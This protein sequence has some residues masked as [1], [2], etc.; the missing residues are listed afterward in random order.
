MKL[1]VLPSRHD[2]ESVVEMLH[3]LGW[4]TKPVGN[5][6]E[7]QPSKE[8]PSVL[9]SAYSYQFCGTWI[10]PIYSKVH[11]ETFIDLDTISSMLLLTSFDECGSISAMEVNK[12]TKTIVITY[13]LFIPSELSERAYLMEGIMSASLSGADFQAN[14]KRL[15]EHIGN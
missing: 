3:S 13:R 14:F 15:H 1:E 2:L 7:V 9:V 10:R 8:S 11:L 12:E 6:V 5:F 4:Q